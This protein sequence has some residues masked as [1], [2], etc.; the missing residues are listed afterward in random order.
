MDSGFSCSE[1]SNISCD[2]LRAALMLICHEN[3]ISCSLILKFLEVKTTQL[4]NFLTHNSAKRCKR[5]VVY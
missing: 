3:A 2:T 4:R 1:H 5:T